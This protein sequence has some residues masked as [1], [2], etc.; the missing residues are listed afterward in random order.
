[1]TGVDLFSQHIGQIKG[2]ENFMVLR[3]DGHM[4]THNMSQP[5][6]MSSLA[7]LTGI[8]AQS[9]QKTMGFT[10]F[11]YLVFAREHNQS[12]I[13]F[14]LDKFYVGILAKTGFNLA[15]LIEDIAKFLVKIKVK[16]NP[17]NSPKEEEE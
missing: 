15:E 9:I 5:E 3:H 12:L 2:V 16:R 4:L 17:G 8:S 6:K 10:P 1:M 11:R 14:T 7:T 13:I